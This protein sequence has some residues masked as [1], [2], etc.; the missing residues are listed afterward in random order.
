V[1]MLDR[2]GVMQAG[3]AM[4]KIGRPAT[5]RVWPTSSPRLSPLLGQAQTACRPMQERT[6]KL[7]LAHTCTRSISASREATWELVR[8]RARNCKYSTDTTSCMPASSGRFRKVLTYKYA[9]W[10]DLR[11]CDMLDPVRMRHSMDVSR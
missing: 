7:M 1:Y 5:T 4:T 11:H 10:A 8:P 6:W 2:H 9:V 3:Q